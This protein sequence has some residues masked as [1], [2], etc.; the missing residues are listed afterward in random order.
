[1]FTAAEETAAWTEARGLLAASAAAG[2]AVVLVRDGGLAEDA[3][4]LVRARAILTESKQRMTEI[5]VDPASDVASA[6]ALSARIDAAAVVVAIGGGALLDLVAM[7]RACRD[8]RCIAVITAPQ[9]AGLVALPMTAPETP[10]IIAVPT[11]IGTGAESSTVAT[12]VIDGARR[13]VLG[14][15]LRADVAVVDADATSGMPRDLYA[16]GLVEIMLRLA[17]PY[18]SGA[19]APPFADDVALALARA[20]G[21]LSEKPP[22]RAVR[23]EA[24]R[25]SA[26]SHSPHLAHPAHTFGTR[27]WYVANEL[28]S[29]ASVTKMAALVEITPPIWERILAG[30]DRW[31]DADRLRRFWVDAAPRSVSTEPAEGLREWTRMLGAPGIAA[32]VRAGL[33]PAALADV[34]VR[35]W[36]YGL[37]MLGPLRRSDLASLFAGLAPTR[38]SWGMP[39][40]RLPIGGFTGTRSQREGGKK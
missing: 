1:M 7:A 37:P 40:S 23:E 10:A 34:C 31:G 8:A 35:R 30:D 33:D 36:G 28:A 15:T 6:I 24:A 5:S 14:R 20:L 2:G 22:S 11:T 17:G 12:C 32:S 38:G 25:I 26:L 29:A 18:V 9:R 21:A 3:R 19:G 13:L 4:V 16:S 27:A 39:R